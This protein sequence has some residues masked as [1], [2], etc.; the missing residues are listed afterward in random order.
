MACSD[1]TDSTV[2][3]ICV[4]SLAPTNGEDSE[5]EGDFVIIRLREEEHEEKFKLNK[6]CF[7]LSF[8]GELGLLLFLPIGLLLD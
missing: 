3:H 1:Y 2:L 5:E 4:V 6:V 7:L 8:M